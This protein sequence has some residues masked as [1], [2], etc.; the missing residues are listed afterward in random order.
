MVLETNSSPFKKNQTISLCK[1]PAVSGGYLASNTFACTVLYHSS[2]DQFLC[3]KLV[4]RSNMALTSCACGLQKS[5]YL[6]H[7]VSKQRSSVGKHQETYWSIPNAPFQARAF[8]H[9]FDSGNMA[10]SQSRIFSHFTFQFKNLWYKP[11]FTVHSSLGPS[12]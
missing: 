5:S 3:L 8:L 9:S 12:I 6:G 7:I 2:T 4:G 1:I 10:S 11:S